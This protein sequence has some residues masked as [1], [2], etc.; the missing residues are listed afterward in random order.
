M[1]REIKFRAWHFGHKKMFTAEE[2][3]RDQMALLPDGHFANIHSVDTRLSRIYTHDEMLPLQY[4]GIKD[5]N[6]KEIYEGDIVRSIIEYN[7]DGYG[8]FLVCFHN[9]MFFAKRC[10][11]DDDCDGLYDLKYAQDYFDNDFIT[12]SPMLYILIEEDEII[13]V[14]GNIYENLELLNQ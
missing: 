5:K 11:D 9:G 3:T 1:N 7:D 2:M 12:D 10:Y 8:I 13:E 6:G 14:I 4:T